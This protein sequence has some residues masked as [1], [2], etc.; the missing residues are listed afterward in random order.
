MTAEKEHSAHTSTLWTLSENLN[1]TQ[2]LPFTE[3]CIEDENQEIVF[4]TRNRRHAV[5]IVKS[6]NERPTMLAALEKAQ[7]ALQEAHNNIGE[8]E[9]AYSDALAEVN[10]SLAKAKEA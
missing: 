3:Y 9:T 10:A 2:D 6:V 4:F 8:E 7:K 1:D 5:L